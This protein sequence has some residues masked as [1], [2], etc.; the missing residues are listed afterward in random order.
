MQGGLVTQIGR[1]R[2]QQPLETVRCVAA[3]HV[4]QDSKWNW[5]RRAERAISP[6]VPSNS[7]ANLEWGELRR[8]ESCSAVCQQSSSSLALV[9]SCRGDGILFWIFIQNQTAC[10]DGHLNTRPCIRSDQTSA[11]RFLRD[12][13]CGECCA[14]PAR[15]PCRP[16]TAGL[17][18]TRDVN[19]G[20]PGGRVGEVADGKVPMGWQPRLL[21]P[22]DM[23]AAAWG[24]AAAAMPRPFG[25]PFEMGSLFPSLEPGSQA[26]DQITLL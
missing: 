7:T 13:G 11:S 14:K 24:G 19:A 5:S 10:D 9:S 23:H 3:S 22:W 21:G 8:S 1:S 17:G 26:D 20:A 16:L 2:H 15:N 25:C 4:V 6:R 12:P 18:N